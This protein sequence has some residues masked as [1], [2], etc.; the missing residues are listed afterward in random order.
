M[1]SSIFSF[2][3]FVIAA[4]L[5]GL[6]E[7]VCALALR[8]GLVE[9]ANLG[10]LDLYEDSAT[11]GKLARFADSSP[12][13]IQVGDSSGFH[14]VRPELVM[15]HLGGLKYVNLSCCASVG[16]RGYYGVADFMLRRNPGVKAVVLYVSLNGLPR[17]DLIRGDHQIGEYIADL[18]TAPFAHL[19]PPTVALRQH[20]VDRVKLSRLPMNQAIFV[21]DLKQSTQQHFGWW[22]EHDRRLAA[23]KR[24]EYWHRICGDTG[25]PVKDDGDI[26]YGDDVLRGRYS[27]MRA[28]LQRFASLAAEHGAKFIL[29]F[30]PF[31][32]RGVDGNFLTARREDLAALLKQNRNMIALPEEMLVPWP[33]ERFVSSDH[34]H[35][36]YDEENS[37]RLG[38]LLAQALGV[39]N[40]GEAPATHDVAKSTA[41]DPTPARSVAVQWR[42]E[43]AV[44]THDGIVGESTLVEASGSG[45]HRI[46][47]TLVGLTPGAIA[48]L[49]FPARPIG[50]RGVLI[51][52]ETGAH[53]GGGFCDLVGETATR[54]RDMLDA[55]LEV[56]SDRTRCW[57]A[58]PLTESAATLRLTLLDRSLA[59][60]Y[61]GDGRSGVAI[62][63]IELRETADFLQG[64]SSPW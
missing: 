16:Y 5:I 33:T 61:V 46:N 3:T 2:R 26:F 9:R 38:R 29:A 53:A 24:T 37:R 48:V 4:V 47:G 17:A 31:S 56:T 40:G 11:F 28:E 42:S 55:G 34:L 22:A 27:Y 30:H 15:R 59:R 12:D 35:I 36:G 1:S 32:C 14:G 54:E 21:A 64:E 8:P 13:I 25:V 63:K 6:I 50:A 49:S 52:L 45:V 7:G 60:S 58:M 41:S 23:P 57:V 51:E 18:L 10:L 39:G 44:V 62:G 43:G 19:A 20:I